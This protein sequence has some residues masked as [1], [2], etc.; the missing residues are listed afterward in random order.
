MGKGEG[1]EG[2]GRLMMGLIK[3]KFFLTH[4]CLL[5]QVYFKLQAVH[6]FTSHVTAAHHDFEE[7]YEQENESRNLFGSVMHILLFTS[8]FT[9]D[10]NG[11]MKK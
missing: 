10:I 4:L 11:L 6:L 2:E 7:I 1:G 8:F 9:F 5:S 3:K